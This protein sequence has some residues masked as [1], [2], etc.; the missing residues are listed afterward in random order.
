[1]NKILES[2]LKRT[3]Q[4]HH[5]DWVGRLILN[6]WSYKTKW[7]DMMGFTLYKLSKV[8]VLSFQLN[9]RLIIWILLYH[10]KTTSINLIKLM[11]FTKTVYT[12]PLLFN[13]NEQS[14]TISSL[15]RKYFRKETRLCF[16]TPG[17]RIPSKI[18]SH[19]S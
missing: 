17:L 1:M 13:N 10:N 5:H 18:F 16:M 2:I 9:L 19:T 7:K 6:I 8:S 4:I 12:K 14:G 11:R 15:R 3:M